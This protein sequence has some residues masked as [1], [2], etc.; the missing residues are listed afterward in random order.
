MNV[1]KYKFYCLD[2]QHCICAKVL[3]FSAFHGV[4]VCVLCVSVMAHLT[5]AASVR[6]ENT[7]TY[8]VGNEGKKVS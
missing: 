6:P 1:T 5:Y 3:H 7:A 2:A 4:S 8:S